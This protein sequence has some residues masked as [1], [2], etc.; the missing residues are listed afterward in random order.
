MPADRSAAERVD[1]Y[2]ALHAETD[3]AGLLP[4]F[5]PDAIVED[6]VGGEIRRGRDEIEAFYRATHESN[7]RLVIERV[8]PV[9][10]GGGEAAAHVRARFASPPDAPTVD[11]IYVFGFDPAGRIASL[12]A[13]FEL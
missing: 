11:V 9:V 8:G 2:L 7:G 5:A 13:F 12:R 6:P 4:L 1:R 10:C 3:L